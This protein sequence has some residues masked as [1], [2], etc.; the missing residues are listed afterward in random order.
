MNYQEGNTDIKYFIYVRKSSE[1]KERQ[2]LS[3]P[4]QIEQIEK[5]FG[6]LDYETIQDEKSAFK[7]YNRPGFENM[8]K[9]IHAGDRTGI[10]AWHPD[11]IS[12][13]EMD[14]AAITYALRTDVI[15]DLLFVNYNFDNTPEGIWMLQLALSQSQLESAKK[16]KDV[17]R[18]ERL[19]CQ[20]GWRPGV[21]P[22]GYENY[23]DHIDK[24]KKVRIDESQRQIVRRMFD[25]M[26]TGLYTPPQIL[27]IANDEWG[28]R[29][30]NGKKLVKSGIYNLFTRPFY[31]GE[32][33]FPEDSGEWYEG[34]H[35]PYITRAEFDTIQRILGREGRPRS[36]KH[37]HSY[38][39]FI[40]CGECGGFVTQEHKKKVQKNGTVHHYYL[41]HCTKRNKTVRCSQ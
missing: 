14:A 20:M 24:V 11:R 31:Y 26:L 15:H 1:Q 30:K 23:E 9:R 29:S 21:A 13:N 16:G 34:R 36:Q 41:A 18:G 33:Q 19:K 8:M 2:N 7:P 17:K 12:R 25:L 40:R 39:G 32:F 38:T 3:I 4:A 6:H 10:I 37:K 22:L 28:Y 27:T 35:E 5:R